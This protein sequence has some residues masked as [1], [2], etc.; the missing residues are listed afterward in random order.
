MQNYKVTYNQFGQAITTWFDNASKA[1]GYAK[2]VAR[3]GYEPSVMEY[4]AGDYG[5]GREVWNI[6]LATTRFFQGH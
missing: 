3:L 1:K 5:K 6:S 4:P 2:R